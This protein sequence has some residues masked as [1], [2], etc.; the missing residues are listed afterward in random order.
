MSNKKYIV[1]YDEQGSQNYLIPKDPETIHPN[2]GPGYPSGNGHGHGHEIQPSHDNHMIQYNDT[3]INDYDFS[4]LIINIA[5]N[6]LLCLV[7][8]ELFKR[9]YLRFFIYTQSRNNRRHT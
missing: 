8:I 1:Y 2:H 5:F 6:L 4:Y 9:C 7:F 3:S